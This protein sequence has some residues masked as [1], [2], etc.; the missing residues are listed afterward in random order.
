MGHKSVSE[1]LKFN[2]DFL[3]EQ[4][5]SNSIEVIPCWCVSF[6]GSS[7]GNENQGKAH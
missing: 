5:S 6:D 2:S 7:V 4:R 1:N 3:A